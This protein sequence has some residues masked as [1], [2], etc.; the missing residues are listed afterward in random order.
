MLPGVEYLFNCLLSEPIYREKTTVLIKN[1]KYYS[2]CPNS[3]L[4]LYKCCLQY[5]LYNQQSNITCIRDVL[6]NVSACMTRRG[7][8]E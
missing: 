6:F 2:F 5:Y 7:K 8:R 3:I 4:F 1:R